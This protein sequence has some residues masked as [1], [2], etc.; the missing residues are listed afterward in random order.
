MKL[1]IQIP[2]K[3]EEQTLP[4][5]VRDLPRQIP[6]IDTIEI[7]VIDDGSTDRTAEVAAE[8]GVHHIVRHISNKGLA[9]AFQTG[10]DAA[11][12]LGADIIVN[13]DGDHQYPGDQIPLLVAPILDGRADIVIGDRQPHMVEHFSLQKRLLQRIG[14]W[15]VRRAS[16]TSVP[17][18]V[19]GFRALSREAALRLF[20]STEFSYTVENLIQAGKRRLTVAHVPVRVNPTRP[21]RLHKGN[22]NF[23]KRQAATIVRT[24]ATYEPFKTFT[25]IAA[26]FVIAGLLF[27]LRAAYVF[28]G[29]RVGFAAGENLQALT[30]G[31]GLLVLGF[32]VF[33]I[34]LVADRIGGNRRMLEEILYRIRRAELDDIGW[35]QRVERRLD[36][37]ETQVL[38]ELVTQERARHVNDSA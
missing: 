28:I 31:T 33:L 7:L 8:L 21:S 14:S 32:I 23:V 16:G 3:D 27:L 30:L 1:I 35:R 11:L 12:R 17:D 25:Y 20:V 6:G 22:W 19:S 18:S 36:A 34:G 10:I 24:Y 29:R 5:V 9:A 2:A 4:Q 15:V 13:T 37:L 38:D 26:P